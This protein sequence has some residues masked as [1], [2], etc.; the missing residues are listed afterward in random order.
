L[1]FFTATSIL[2]RFQEHFK[3]AL[4]YYNAG[5]AVANSEVVGLAPGFEYQ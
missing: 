3:N 1:Y 4:A 2:V 5:V